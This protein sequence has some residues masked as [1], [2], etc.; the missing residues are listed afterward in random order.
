MFSNGMFGEKLKNN[1]VKLEENLY[2][3]CS[4]Y[5]FLPLLVR[6]S[7]RACAERPSSSIHG[8]HSCRL[9]CQCR[10][11]QGKTLDEEGTTEMDTKLRP[12]LQEVS[13]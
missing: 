4:N 13:Y 8:V 7:F 1:F 9:S 2:Q 11:V 3:T 5:C 10:P 6:S 12:N